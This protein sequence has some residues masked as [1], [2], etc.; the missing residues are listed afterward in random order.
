MRIIRNLSELGEPRQPTVVTVGNF[1]GVHL[2]HQRL[3]ASVVQTARRLGAAATAVTFD[4]HPTRILA[5]E[6]TPK[7]L[8]TLQQKTRLIERL[9]IELLVVLPFTRELSE[10]TP[11]EFVRQVLVAGLHAVSVHVGQN[12]RFGHRQEGDV[13]ML[14]DLSRK[15]GFQLEVLPVVEMRDERVSSSRIRQ[16]LSEGRVGRAGRLLGRPYSVGGAIVHG[17]G[18]GKTQTVPTLNLAPVEEQ[19]PKDGVYVTRTRLGERCHESV[20]NVGHKPTFG[21]HRLTVESFLLNF[22]GELHAAEMKVEFLYRL[23]DEV[24]FPDAGAL[25]AQIQKDVRR[26]VKFF[27]LVKLLKRRETQSVAPA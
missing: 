15:L 1:D 13:P 24:K 25:K 17:S 4:P 6:R 16:L 18:V 10:L 8:T 21:E 14:A 9:G 27:R 26:S 2:A 23:R 5:P 11:L 20:S 7:L 12:F 22:S 3:F 19:L